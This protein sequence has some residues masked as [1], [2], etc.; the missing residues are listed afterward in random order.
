[1]HYKNKYSIFKNYLDKKNFLNL[2]LNT[3]FEELEVISNYQTRKN[4]ENDGLDFIHKHFPVEYLPFL[5]DF[6]ANEAHKFIR[7]NR[8]LL[9]EVFQKINRYLKS[10]TVSNI[11]LKHLH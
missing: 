9:L 7:K 1:M 10:S 6:L 11:F 3:I 8:Q 4:V 5:Q 2:C